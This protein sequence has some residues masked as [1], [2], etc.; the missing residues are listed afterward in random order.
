MFHA[1]QTDNKLWI[2]GIDYNKYLDKYLCVEVNGDR[3]LLR[4]SSNRNGLCYKPYVMEN[5]MYIKTR[6]A[7]PGRKFKVE[8]RDDVIILTP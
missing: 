5:R 2:F 6:V 4:V 7:M 8:I 1:T 3:I